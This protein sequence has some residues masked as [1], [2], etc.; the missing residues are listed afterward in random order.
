SALMSSLMGER[1]MPMLKAPHA[2]LYIFE[3]VWKSPTLINN[4]ETYAAV[5]S[6]INNGGAWYAGMGTE[7]SKGTKLLSV[8]GHVAKPGNYEIEMGTPLLE[9][10]Q[11]AGGPVGKLKFVVP[12]GCSVPLLPA[13]KLEGVNMDY[14]SL[15]AA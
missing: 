14:E 15:T 8:C 3:G 6:I 13:D 1:G 4:V 2:P 12:G 9:L 7:R 5:P 11:L 10:I